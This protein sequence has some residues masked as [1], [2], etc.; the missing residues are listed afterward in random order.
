VIGRVREKHAS[1]SP[2][3]FSRFAKRFEDGDAGSFQSG[4]PVARPWAAPS[5]TTAACSARPAV[6]KC[7]A[8]SAAVHGPAELAGVERAR[9]RPHRQRHSAI[10]SRAV[11]H[12]GPP[13]FTQWRSSSRS[14]A[15][16]AFSAPGSAIELPIAVV[17]EQ[18]DHCSPRRLVSAWRRWRWPRSGHACWNTPSTAPVLFGQA[19]HQRIN[20]R[21]KRT[22]NAKAG[23][24][25]PRRIA[26]ECLA[27]RLPAADRVCVCRE[28]RRLAG[29]AIR[30]ALAQPPGAASLAPPQQ[31]RG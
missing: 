8:T 31:H 7:W 4:M 10:C 12:R 19:I 13:R 25:R 21:R 29:G 28:S 17:A 11:G 22:S 16:S 6:S 30:Q 26:P 23:P 15:A 14:P 1:A 24:D 2:W 18:I 9:W 27:L 3:A 20:Q 5:S